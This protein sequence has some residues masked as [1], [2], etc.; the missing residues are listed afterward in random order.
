MAAERRERLNEHLPR[1]VGA[2]TPFCTAFDDPMYRACVQSVTSIYTEKLGS[3][4]NLDAEENFCNS[5][6]Y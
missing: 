1:F 6:Y 3:D 2:L 4:Q 5:K